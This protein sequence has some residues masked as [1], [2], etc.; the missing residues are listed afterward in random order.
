LLLWRD[1]A[2]KSRIGGVLAAAQFFGSQLKCPVERLIVLAR[3]A[4]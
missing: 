3:N 4:R 2:E 1:C